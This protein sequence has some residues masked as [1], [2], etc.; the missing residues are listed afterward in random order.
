M[1]LPPKDYIV[2]VVI[3]LLLLLFS[4]KLA[5][6]ARALTLSYQKHFV[7]VKMKLICFQKPMTK[8]LEIS[9]ENHT[10]EKGI[11]SVLTTLLIAHSGE[12]WQKYLRTVRGL[13][14]IS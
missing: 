8:N 10:L 2:R 14:E 7:R 9:T 1:L 13:R 4:R 5:L 3:A 11:I 6:P 12:N